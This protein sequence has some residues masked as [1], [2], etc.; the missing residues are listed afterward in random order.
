MRLF[1]SII[2]SIAITGGI[3]GAVFL[4]PVAANVTEKNVIKRQSETSIQSSKLEQTTNDEKKTLRGVTQTIPLKA[5]DK[6]W[7]TFYE[8]SVANKSLPD[9]VK[10]LI[11]IYQNFNPDYSEAKVTIG[12]E[13]QSNNPDNVVILFPPEKQMN[14]VLSQGKH[15]DEQLTDAWSK[16]NFSKQVKAV[17]EVHHLNQH[18]L[19]DSS[20][21]SVYYK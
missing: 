21:L 6:L 2:T 7:N 12:Y 1:A 9:S 16:I 5:I 14:V 19:P 4:Q 3:W 20:Q 10:Q 15:T 17:V 11:V 13:A 18:G 8:Q